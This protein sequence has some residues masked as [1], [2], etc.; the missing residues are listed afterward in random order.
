MSLGKNRPKLEPKT[1]LKKV[2]ANVALTVEKGSTKM[3]ATYILLQFSEKLPK[4]SNPP[5][6]ENS[7]NLATMLAILH[8]FVTRNAHLKCVKL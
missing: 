3:R 4:V 2:N 8:C 7:P 6:G 5:L 1:F